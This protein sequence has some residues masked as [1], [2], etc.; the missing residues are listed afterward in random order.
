M[1]LLL[2]LLLAFVPVLVRQSPVGARSGPKLAGEPIGV[3]NHW[4]CR[5]S[6]YFKKTFPEPNH[7]V[8]WLDS[9]KLNAQ[10]LKCSQEASPYCRACSSVGCKKMTLTNLSGSGNLTSRRE[11]SSS[12]LARSCSCG[13]FSPEDTSNPEFCWCVLQGGACEKQHPT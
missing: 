11:N 9:G 5:Q 3:I 12:H 1:L 4:M 8:G 10:A 2:L 13:T 7:V 6:P